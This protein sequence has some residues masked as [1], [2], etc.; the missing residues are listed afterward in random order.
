MDYTFSFQHHAR[1]RGGNS[2]STIISLYDDG[3]D[4]APPPLGTTKPGY[5]TYSSGLVVTVNTATN[6][7]TLLERYVSPERQLSQ[8]QG[9]FQYLPNNNKFMGMGNVPYMVEFT[10]NAT[11]N[12]QV[13]YYANFTQGESYRMFKFPWKGQPTTPP[14]VFSYAHN[15]SAQMAVYA[16][17]NGATEVASWRISTS[18]AANGRYQRALEAPKV[19]FETQIIIPRSAPYV[20]AEALSANGTVL[21]TSQS[22]GTF[23]PAASLA[24]NCSDVACA[25]G[26]NYTT[27]GTIA[28][29]NK[30]RTVH[31]LRSRDASNPYL[32][33]K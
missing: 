1:F 15:C 3:S 22:T 19:G 26:T 28:C 24:G 33:R 25:P 18:Y 20:I 14:S 2:S 12:A 31:I 9:S 11:G 23:V 10:S 5:E 27:A 17:W 7:S 21:G 6:T 16:S 13:V 4:D 30:V 29:P 32:Q 8:S